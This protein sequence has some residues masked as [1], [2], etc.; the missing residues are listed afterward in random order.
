[1]FWGFFC[2]PHGKKHLKKLQLLAKDSDPE[3]YSYLPSA[4]LRPEVYG[5][6]LETLLPAAA[7]GTR[8]ADRP[9]TLPPLPKAAGL[10]LHLPVPSPRER[11]AGRT[12]PD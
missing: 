1:M 2:S 11:G 12:S 3:Y 7:A 9:L 10:S 6:S 5:V 8:G 4:A